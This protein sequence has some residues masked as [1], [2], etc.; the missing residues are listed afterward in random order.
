MLIFMVLA[1]GF[2]LVVVAC[3]WYSREPYRFYDNV[4]YQD[5]YE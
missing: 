1:L 4:D 2:V 5:V 3:S